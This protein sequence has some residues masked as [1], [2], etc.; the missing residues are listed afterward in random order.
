[1]GLGLFGELGLV[2]KISYRGRQRPVPVLAIFLS[3]L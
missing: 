1:M 3:T 2:K